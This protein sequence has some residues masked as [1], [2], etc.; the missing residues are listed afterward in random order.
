MWLID[1]QE[2]RK[3][4]TLPELCMRSY[5]RQA[6]NE[7]LYK[8]AIRIQARADR[9]CGELQRQFQTSPNGGRPPAPNAKTA[10]PA[11]NPR[12]PTTPVNT[13]NINPHNSR[14]A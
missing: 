13:A 8:T 9:R 10:I 5:A 6:K 14:Q 2:F 7:A 11:S 4:W 1:G 12:Q 3:K